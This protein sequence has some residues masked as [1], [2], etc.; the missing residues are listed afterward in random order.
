MGPKSSAL[1]PSAAQQNLVLDCF[2]QSN[3]R[4]S[5]SPNV[6]GRNRILAPG[7]TVK[8]CFGIKSQ[9][10]VRE[11]MRRRSLLLLSKSGRFEV[12]WK[13]CNLSMVSVGI[14]TDLFVASHRLQYH[15]MTLFTNVLVQR[16]EQIH[17]LDLLMHCHQNLKALS[18]SK[19]MQ[20]GL[21]TVLSHQEGDSKHIRAYV[22]RRMTAQHYSSMK[23]K[24]LALKWAITEKCICS[25][26]SLWF[27]LII[28]INS[29]VVLLYSLCT[30]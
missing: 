9:Q 10:I 5:G 21:D 7:S 23:F 4:N 30:T 20:H 6:L 12:M 1:G 17:L 11:R 19:S 2:K 24:L 16:A 27:W 26:Q 3:S 29:L 14:T 25:D 8:F 18:C 22:L 13:S 15:C 28:L